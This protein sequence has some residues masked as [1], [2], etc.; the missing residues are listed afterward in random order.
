MISIIARV[1]SLE[2]GS[3]LRRRLRAQGARC[4]VRPMLRPLTHTLLTPRL[5][6]EP[7]TPALASA[8]RRGQRAFADAIGAAAPIEWVASSLNQV[9]CS[10]GPPAPTRAV[11]VDRRDGVV[12]GDVRFEAPLRGQF[13]LA[14]F[15]IG[16]SV[17]ASRRR[18]G[19]ASEAAGAVVDWLF[20]QAGAEAILAGCNKDNLASIRTLRR[21]GFWLDSNPGRV[22]WWVLHRSAHLSRRA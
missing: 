12:V 10:A 4:S 15:E 8:A 16:Y 22:F 6:I 2:P 21:L 9:A 20:D 14:D 1:C 18:Q 17:A 19:Y 13:E 7:V 11:A 5:R 3:E